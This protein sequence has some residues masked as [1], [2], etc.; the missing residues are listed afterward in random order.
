[1]AW[2]ATSVEANIVIP[3]IAIQTSVETET[4][5]KIPLITVAEATSTTGTFAIS[6]GGR[7]GHSESWIS[8][9]RVDEIGVAWRH[10][11]IAD[12]AFRGRAISTHVRF[13]GALSLCGSPIAI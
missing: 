11:A 1:M 7:D 13:A 12:Q 5:P 4:G 9:H 3:N 2:I 10:I 6:V 8:A